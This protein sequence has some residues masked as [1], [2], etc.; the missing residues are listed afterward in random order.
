M[1]AEEALLLLLTT[2]VPAAGIAYNVAEGGSGA[3]EYDLHLA[4]VVL[5]AGGA[6][7]SETEITA[8]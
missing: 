2:V 5:R 6:W 3:E 4:E 8:G 7:Q 1:K